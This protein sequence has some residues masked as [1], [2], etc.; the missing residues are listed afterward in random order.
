ME[1]GDTVERK[2]R[3]GSFPATIMGFTEDKSMVL[4][5]FEHGER[6]RLQWAEVGKLGLP[7][8]DAQAAYDSAV[9][10][11][12]TAVESGLGFDAVTPLYRDVERTLLALRESRARLI[13]S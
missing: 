9:L 3:S 5:E 7:E 12:R 4:I 8:S 2:T 6:T 1:I 11:Y 13:G 10:A